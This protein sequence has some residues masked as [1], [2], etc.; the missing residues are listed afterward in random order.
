MLNYGG[1]IRVVGNKP[2]KGRKRNWIGIIITGKPEIKIQNIASPGKTSGRY[3]TSG[4]AL[5]IAFKSKPCLRPEDGDF[6]LRNHQPRE[7]LFC[8]KE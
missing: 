5:I 4:K 1:N 3:T 2:K 6:R 7:F 8:P